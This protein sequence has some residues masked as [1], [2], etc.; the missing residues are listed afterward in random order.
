MYFGV[1]LM[2]EEEEV[3]VFVSLPLIQVPPLHMS[4]VDCVVHLM[5]GLVC[6]SR[7]ELIS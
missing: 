3:S 5:D 4:N 6:F 1:Y 7:D 2:Q